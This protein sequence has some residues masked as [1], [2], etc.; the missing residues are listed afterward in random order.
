MREFVLKGLPS[1]PPFPLGGPRLFKAGDKIRSGPKVGALATSRLPLGESPT[2]HGGGQNEHWGRSG[3]IGYIIP[4]V[5]GSAMLQRR[6]QNEQWP[7]SG[8]LGYNT[9]T[10]LGVPTASKRGTKLAVAHRWADG[11]HH[12]CRRGGSEHFR[13]GGQNQRWPT[14]GRH[15]YTTLVVW[16]FRTALEWGGGISRGEQESRWATS[17]LPCRGFPTLQAGDKMR[18]G[19]QVTEL[20]TSPLLSEGVPNASE[21]GAQ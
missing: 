18:S 3:R 11:L 17:P 15:G 20:V 7:T 2:L 19:P 9:P 12:P 4:A 1:P 14:H 10:V 8:R 6:G 16:V 13:A 21:Q 5:G